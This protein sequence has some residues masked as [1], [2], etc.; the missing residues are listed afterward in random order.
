[1]T[2]GYNYD[3]TAYYR[4]RYYDPNIG[5]FISED[6]IG[7]KGSGTNFYAY[8]K[9]NPINF[10]DPLGLCTKQQCQNSVLYLSILNGIGSALG[11]VNPSLTGTMVDAGKTY[12][13]NPVFAAGVGVLVSQLG[14]A[15]FTG[16]GA[17]KLTGL[18]TEYA[19]PG[20]GWIATGYVAYNA[21]T[22]AIDYYNANIGACQ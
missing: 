2:R 17:V 6:P 18:I 1:M 5:R 14:S 7:F 15:V 10:G 22:D 8:T 9:N 19:L 12:A 16:A 21:L 20:V 11:V 3:G 4:A 13:T